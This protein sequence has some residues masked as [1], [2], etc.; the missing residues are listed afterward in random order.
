MYVTT[1][2][3]QSPCIPLLCVLVLPYRNVL[4]HPA[5]MAAV[6]GSIIVGLSIGLSIFL[7]GHALER[8]ACAVERGLIG[9]GSGTVTNKGRGR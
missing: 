8:G 6:S 5:V 9:F 3:Q 1:A 2:A 7:H 4:M